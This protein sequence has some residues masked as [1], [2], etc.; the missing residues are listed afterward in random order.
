MQKNT[1]ITLGEHFDTFISKQVSEG[2]YA[3]TSETIRAGLRLLEEHETKLEVLRT[4]LIQ[5]E[6]SSVA[7]HYSLQNLLTKL[8]DES[9]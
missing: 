1:S 2:R 5:G 4:A 9:S 8:D 7:E 3:S 6:E